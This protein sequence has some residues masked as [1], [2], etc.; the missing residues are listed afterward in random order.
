[1][2]DP[3]PVRNVLVDAYAALGLDWRPASVGAVTDHAPGVTVADVEP[4]LL[5]VFRAL[6]PQ[7]H[8]GERN[9][10]RPGG[11]TLDP[12]AALVDPRRTGYIT[13]VA[14]PTR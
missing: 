2:T 4:A 6:L 7:A 3:E 9:T 8:R 13:A 12:P 10:S 1:M 5:T 14:T 11:P